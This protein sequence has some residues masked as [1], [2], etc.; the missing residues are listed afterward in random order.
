MLVRRLVFALA[1]LLFPLLTFAPAV[2]AQEVP[3]VRVRDLGQHLQG[4]VTVQG[5]TGYIVEKYERPGMHVF[6]LRDD[7]NDQVFVRTIA[8]AYP[9]MGV[10]YRVTGWAKQ[11]NGVMFL[12]AINGN[13]LPAY[14]PAPPKA[15]LPAGATMLIW[16]AGIV[17]A[18]AALS[19]LVFLLRRILGRPQPEWGELTVASGPDKGRTIPLRRN[20]VPLGRGVS[21]R[22]GIRLSPGDSTISNTHVIFSY[23]NGTL[24][25][26]DMSRNGTRIGGERLKLGVPTPINSGDLIHLGTQGTVVIVRTREIAPPT[27]FLSHLYDPSPASDQT[28]M[29]PD[30]APDEP[31]WSHNGVAALEEP[32]TQHISDLDPSEASEDADTPAGSHYSYAAIPPRR[33]ATTPDPPNEMMP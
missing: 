31:V 4:I 10:T 33:P 21:A 20:R 30:Q 23:R 32:E 28:I 11:A 22:R 9:V 17:L 3:Q 18:L 6:T 25:C 24:F 14:P 8:S 19:L 16:L 27:G 13:F 2:R 26:C 1:T 29:F 7:Y 5:R 15:S 12:D